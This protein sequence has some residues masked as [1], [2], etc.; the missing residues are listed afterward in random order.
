MSEI[1]RFITIIRPEFMTFCQDACRSA[2]LNHLLFRIAYKCKDQPKEKIQA[3]DILWYAKTE[4]ITQEMSN[5]WGTC[6]VR[7]EVNAL[8][9]MG[10][11]G[12]KS[13]PTWGADRTK[14]FC[15]GTEQCQKLIDLC[16]EQN[17]CI[18]HLD[19]PAE[20]MQLIDSSNANDKSI[21]AIPEESLQKIP[22]EDTHK[23][24][25]TYS[26]QS[27][28]PASGS[29]SSPAPATLENTPYRP[30]QET[31]ER[32]AEAASPSPIASDT[33]DPAPS[34]A[35]SSKDVAGPDV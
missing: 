20:V 23:E 35:H 33:P 34:Q 11:L 17:V 25:G 3:G 31:D 18:V 27:A 21:R 4:L 12:R 2:A 1:S 9:D 32:H 16:E 26:A 28:P 14:H 24:E 5:A 29:Q 10:L 6:K 19:L 30:D 15:F 22:T 13:N 7:K 8:V